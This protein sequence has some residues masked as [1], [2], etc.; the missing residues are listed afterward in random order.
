MK[1]PPGCLTADDVDAVVVADP[2]LEQGESRE[3]GRH[4][5]L[6]Q[7]ERLV[8]LD[9][10]EH[11]AGHAVRHAV[12][13]VALG[14][15]DVVGADPLQDPCVLLGLRLRPDV[16]DAEVGQRRGGQDR[17]LDG[18]ADRDHGMVHVGDAE[19]AQR[20]LVGGVGLHDVGQLARRD[21]DQVLVGVD[22]QH[23][24]AERSAA[25][26]GERPAEAAQADHHDHLGSDSSISQ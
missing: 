14:E 2:R 10:L 19:L 13:H 18:V 3:P 6:D 20:R 21:L 7:G 1:D 23:L 9:V 12:T 8:D 5:R 11:L 26:V 22:P 4:R 15:H 24:V 17:R 16:G 25:R